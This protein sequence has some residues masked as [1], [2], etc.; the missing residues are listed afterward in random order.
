MPRP[1]RSRVVV[2]QLASQLQRDVHRLTASQALDDYSRLR[3]Q[4]DDA[5]DAL[6]RNIADAVAAGRDADV[7]RHVRV[8]R[9]SLTAV[10]DGLQAALIRKCVTD[11]DLR[12]LREVVGRLYPALNS[13]LI[14]AVN[15]HSET[16]A[17]SRDR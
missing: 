3:E 9:V 13:L 5:V 2:T 11:N 15:F 16:C 7:A 1:R 14:V 12:G 6:A 8:A 4:I 17:R 10:R